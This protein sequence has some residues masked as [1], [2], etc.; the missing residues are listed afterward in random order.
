[1]NLSKDQLEE[2]RLWGRNCIPAEKMAVMLQLSKND[3]KL[4]IFDFEDL[5]SEARQ[6]WEDGK[7]KAEIEVMESMETF[8]MKGEEGSGEAA[9]ALG[10]MKSKQRLNQLKSNLFGI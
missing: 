6:I 2:I 7:T 10:W 1:M 5:D 9:K 4:F 3:K 8:S